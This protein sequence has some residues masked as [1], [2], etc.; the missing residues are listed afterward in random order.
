[1]KKSTGIGVVS[2]GVLLCVIAF[3][4]WMRSSRTEPEESLFKSVREDVSGTPS[5]TPTPALSSASQAHASEGDRRLIGILNQILASKNDND[6]RLDTDFRNLAPGTKDLLEEKYKSLPMESRNERGT[7][8]FLIGRELNRP[9]DFR[10]LEEVG[11]EPVCLSL[12]DCKKEA[13][14]STEGMHEEP[15]VSVT[16]AY[17]QHVAV[18]SLENLLA[19]NQASPELITEALNTLDSLTTSPVAP[20]AQKAVLLKTRFASLRH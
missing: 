17:P 1:M 15:S 19:S 5:S 20:I 7:I 11:Q 4:F 18:K 2:V 9:E 10:F 8:V 3:L 12:G 6:P 16:L 14:A 13:P